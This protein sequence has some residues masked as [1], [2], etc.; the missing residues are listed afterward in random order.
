MSEG[1]RRRW[2]ATALLLAVATLGSDTPLMAAAETIET[3]ARGI[4]QFRIGSGDRRFGDLEFVGGF[5]Y[6]SSDRRLAGVSA[7]RMRDDGERFL[8]VT[9]AGLWFAGAIRRDA[10]GRPMGLADTR[11]APMLDAAGRTYGRKSDAD[12]EGLALAG[13]RAIVSFEGRHRI[14]SFALDEGDALPDGER[15]RPVPMPLTRHELRSNGGIETIAV[16]PAASPLRGATVVVAERSIDENGNLYGAILERGAKGVFAVR[17][18]LPWAV[19]DG[20]FLPD[21]DLVLLERRYEGFGRIGMRLR[22][23]AGNDIRPGATVDGPV[24]LE[25]D[26]GN[27]IDNMEGLDIWRNAAGETVLSL[28][29][30][31]NGSLFQRNLY[32]EFRLVSPD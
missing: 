6:R 2:A 16:A 25:A 9:D 18:Q 32:L 15:P 19:T 1:M 22:R 11:L 10:D 4:S 31:D 7:F 28:V 5:S 3:S 26:L 20:A 12:A 27:E 13:G 30:D 24:M 29:S 8:A 21:G 23:I 17:R 14:E